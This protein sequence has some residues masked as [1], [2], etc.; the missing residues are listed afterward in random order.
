MNN[1]IASF[2]LSA[3]CQWLMVLGLS[4]LLIGTISKVKAFF[5]GKRGPS[6]FQPYYDLTKLF[7]KSCAYSRTTT[8]VF[9]AAP[10]VALTSMLTVALM[11]PI[12]GFRAPLQFAGDIFLAAYLLALARF[13]MIEAAMD[14]GFS[15][16]GMGASRE[17]FF[18][19]L[20]EAVLFMNFATLA[21]LARSLSLSQMIG[22]DIPMSWRLLGPALLL[23]VASLFILLLTENCR[24]P[25]DD[26]DTHLELTMIH[27]VMLLDHSGPDL[28]YM[29][30]AAAVKLLL[31]AAVLVPII[32]P[33]HTGY[34]PADI[35]CFLGGV[36]GLAALVGIIESSMARL[37][38]SRVRNFLLF[39]L[40]MAFFGFIVTL[41]R[42]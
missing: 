34:P 2:V 1:T 3:L 25:V 27:E 35:L 42:A 38:I 16:E 30:Y 21:L 8:W 26:P 20:S 18:A 22:A 32:I 36:L 17:A 11:V 28:G 40:A 39:A 23:V 31:F 29:L 13:F 19:C 15:M 7:R 10:V 41:W 4:P 33:V 24:I 5:A 37:R 14:T 9:R 6:L 12:G